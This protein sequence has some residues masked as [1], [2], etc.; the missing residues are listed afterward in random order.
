MNLPRE[1]V[2]EKERKLQG[3][4]ASAAAKSTLNGPWKVFD[5]NVKSCFRKFISVMVNLSLVSEPAIAIYKETGGW[6]FSE[7]NADNYRIHQNE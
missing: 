7:M 1:I 5:E 2:I 3:M 6:L 4:N